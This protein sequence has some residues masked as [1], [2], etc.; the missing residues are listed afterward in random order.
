MIWMVWDSSIVELA[1]EAPVGYVRTGGDCDDNEAAAFPGNPEIYDGIDN[2]CDGTVDDAFVA[3]YPDVDNDNFGDEAAEPEWAVSQPAGKVLDNTDCDDSTSQIF[4]GNVEITDGIDNNCDG[5]IDEVFITYYLDADEDGYGIP[6][7]SIVS[8]V[9]PG[10]GYSPSSADCDDANPAINPGVSEDNTI[11]ADYNCDGRPTAAP[12]AVGDYGPAGG[13]VFY[14]YADGNTGLEA[15]P[16][17]Q[18]GTAS[19]GDR[20]AEWGCSSV[21]VIGT[22]TAIGMGAAS[23]QAI[24]AMNCSPYMPG[25][26]L[27]VNLV[28]NYSLNGYRDWFLPSKDELNELYL[29][30]ASVPN[31][32]TGA[33]GR[34]YYWTSSESTGNGAWHEHY[35]AGVQHFGNGDQLYDQKATPLRVRAVRAF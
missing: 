28:I 31:L 18:T 5:Q 20:W 27:A 22:G 15:A 1:V 17:D 8:D 32:D 13:I 33:Y 21:Q 3:W 12:Y 26:D 30:R 35:F 29:Q 4:P 16:E 23:T 7:T 2:D 34:P 6:D 19:T 25:K 24:A 14:L 9:D 10:A 11:Y